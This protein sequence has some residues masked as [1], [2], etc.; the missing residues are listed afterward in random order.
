[1]TTTTKAFTTQ[2]TTS[3]EALPKGMQAFAGTTF[4][5]TFDDY[6]E[7]GITRAFFSN[8]LLAWSET[9]VS[10][11]PE[12]TRWNWKVVFTLDNDAPDLHTL[13]WALACC[14]RLVSCAPSL[15]PIDEEPPVTLLTLQELIDAPPS[16]QQVELI[17]KHIS[18][19]R[20]EFLEKE[21]ALAWA[22]AN[23]GTANTERRA[24]FHEATLKFADECREASVAVDAPTSEDICLQY[25]AMRASAEVFGCTADNEFLA[26]VRLKGSTTLIENTAMPKATKKTANREETLEGPSTAKGAKKAGSSKAVIATRLAPKR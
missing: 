20:T 11:E 1:M 15:R 17:Q 3:K 4:E 7:C 22:Q 13:R 2:Q 9:P 26:A 5:M 10:V 6:R 21:D 24:E 25:G 14:K 18:R 23:A 8:W 16:D 12:S 19:L